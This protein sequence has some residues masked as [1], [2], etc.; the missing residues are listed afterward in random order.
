MDRATTKVFVEIRSIEEEMI[1]ALSDQT[2]AE[3]SG[4]KTGKDIR[5]LQKRI[6][7]EELLGVEGRNEL[8]KLQVDILNTEAHNVKLAET[9]KLLDDEVN[10][11]AAS[12][13]KYE[14]EIKRRNDEIEKKT[15]DIDSLNKRLERMVGN[16]VEEDSTGPLEAVIRNL[17]RE[18]DLKGVESKELQRRWIGY[19]TELVALTNENAQLS[20][21]VAR[22]KAEHTVLFQKKRRLESQLE[23]QQKEFRSLQAGMARLG[24]DLQRVNSLIAQNSSAKDA[25]KED[26]FNLENRV[27][28]E[29]KALEEEA[30][31]ISSQI[32]GER[33]AKRETLD[34]VVEA[35]RQIML[36]ERKIILE[37]VNSLNPLL[38]PLYSSD[39]HTIAGDA[40]GP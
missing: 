4:S 12:V 40:R 33:A 32:D 22:M 18:I 10:D 37:K 39:P 15:R 30:A 17:Q 29:L 1:I 16:V 34:E 36:W 5:D 7:D 9:L 11:K 2:T 24:V 19:Q 14:L 25:L 8:A 23:S 28:F 3:K 27:M 20:E 38:A 26:N 35:E 21:N 6:R 31:R 13:E